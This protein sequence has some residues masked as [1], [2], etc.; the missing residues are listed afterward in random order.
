M[1]PDAPAFEWNIGVDDF[2]PSSN[3]TPAPQSYPSY[4]QPKS[5]P[6]NYSYNPPPGVKCELS[7]DAFYFY[8]PDGHIYLSDG[9]AQV[10]G[11]FSDEDYKRLTQFCT[12][13]TEE[14]A[15]EVKDNNISF[16]DFMKSRE[17]KSKSSGPKIGFKEVVVVGTD[18][19]PVNEEPVQIEEE[20]FQI[21]IREKPKIK[22]IVEKPID[23]TALISKLKDSPESLQDRIIEPDLKLNPVNIVFIGHVDAGKST[24]CGNIL[25][26]TNKIDKR[27]IETYEQEAKDKGRE[28]W[29]LAYVMDENEEERQKGITV[30]VGRA[31]FETNNKRFTILDAPGHKAYV[32][33]MISGASQ[34]EY[35]AL[36]ISARISEFE[37]GFERGGQTREHA[38]LA[39]S[40][41]VVKLIVIINKMDDPTVNWSQ[42]R[43]EQIKR[44]M[45]PYLI[46]VCKYNIE[47]DIVWVPISGITGEN[48]IDHVSDQKA[49]WYTGPTLFEVFDSLPVPARNPEDP[50]RLPIIDKIKDQG[51]TV[52]GKVES[53]QAVKGLR[54]IIMPIRAKGEIVEIISGQDNKFL[55][56]NPG[57]NVKMKLKVSEEI[58]VVR[59]F[60]ICDVHSVCHT[61]TEFKADVQFLELSDSKMIIT[62]GYRCVIHLHTSIEE[63]EVSEVI[64]LYDVDKKKK[65]K[66]AFARSNQRVIL[67]IKTNNE[68]CLEKYTTIA[69][70]G[71]FVLRDKGITVALGKIIEFTE[72]VEN[73]EDVVN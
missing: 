68:V 25:L 63:C 37:T 58:D 64:A 55:Y 19:V 32:P 59:G 57:E 47:K 30:E 40:F 9:L 67:K 66:S 42:D 41:G 43:Y 49:P 73:S 4:G 51:I 23:K 18:K 36:V 11:P 2:V 21:K 1:N 61:G 16:S 52:Y 28:S 54:V 38:M 31:F 22:L 50:L 62:A 14:R 6:A 70:L 5:Y 46:D 12:G 45:S 8:S 13:E 44:D 33:N 3:P 15:A 7:V 17:S 20:K 60:V 10:F 39:K 71:R 35:A 29:W 72:D 27:V 34:A 65:V 53:G 56:A 48:M 26:L 24:I 69:Q